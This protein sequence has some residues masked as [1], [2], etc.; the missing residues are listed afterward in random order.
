MYAKSMA[1]TACLGCA[2]TNM[3]GLGAYETTELPTLG[4]MGTNGPTID[5]ARVSRLLTLGPL[6]AVRPTTTKPGIIGG[7][8]GPGA[9]GQTSVPAPGAPAPSNGLVNGNGNGLPEANGL[10]EPSGPPPWLVPLGVGIGGLVL[11][12]GVLVILK[13]K[14]KI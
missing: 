10:L 2:R 7:G 3:H 9:A 6:K 12:G 8:L 14:G 11:V 5:P 1:G 4:G 13:K